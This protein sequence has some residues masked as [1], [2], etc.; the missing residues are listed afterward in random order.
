MTT[1]PFDPDE[2]R[3][4]RIRL[5]LTHVATSRLVPCSPSSVGHWERSRRRPNGRPGRAYLAVLERLRET[6]PAAS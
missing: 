1:P 5:G 2:A 3:E 4:L 6:V